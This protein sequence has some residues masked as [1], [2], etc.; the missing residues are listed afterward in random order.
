MLFR[1]L[2]EY[3]N[4]IVGKEEDINELNFQMNDLKSN[5]NNLIHEE[6]NMSKEVHQVSRN[7]KFYEQNYQYINQCKNN[8]EQSYKMI[9][10]I[11][12]Q[13]NKQLDLMEKNINDIKNET[14]IKSE[15][16]NNSQDREN[17]IHLQLKELE[18]LLKS[19][20]SEK[21][22]NI[23]RR[24][25]ILKNIELN[26]KEL[27]QLNDKDAS[28]QKLLEEIKQNIRNKSESV[29]S[30]FNRKAKLQESCERIREQQ[31]REELLE[32]QYSEKYENLKNEATNDY[33]ISINEV[34]NYKNQCSSKKEAN[35]QINDLRE[36]ILEMGQ[37]N[38]DSDNRYQHQLDRFKTLQSKYDEITE[39]KI[40][41][42][43]MVSEIDNIATERFKS[44]FDQVKIYFNEI[45]QSIF[46]GGE[47]ILNLNFNNDIS[48]SEIDIIARP[49]GKKT[50][51]I[52][53]LSSGEKALTAIALLL[54]LWKVNPS[55]FCFFDEIDTA[56]DETNADRLSMILKGKDLKKSQLIV[57]THQKS[58]MEAADTLC[59]IT[60]QESGISKLV[61]VKLT[62]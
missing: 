44:T 1:S 14:I 43:K 39:A 55:P 22:K 49:P 13:K 59:G 18:L 29:E 25:D 34:E 11:I 35:K 41:L 31:H 38:F 40:L 16:I 15:R 24:T 2:E 46:S 8:V 33:H 27:V 9:N 57:I 32:V 26:K 45:F 3:K 47:G 48:Q 61:S 23:E 56:L 62:K 58:T 53:L 37:I 54:S 36:K 42:L 21:Q 17:D 4:Q 52:E 5:I 20:Q 12:L 10:K 50:R 28:D 7:L 30:I 19:K 6:E 51:N 60:M